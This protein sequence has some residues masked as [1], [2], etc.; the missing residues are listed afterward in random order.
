MHGFTTRV[1]HF[2]DWKYGHEDAAIENVESIFSI[3]DN[4]F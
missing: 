3:T 2:S 1:S 4:W